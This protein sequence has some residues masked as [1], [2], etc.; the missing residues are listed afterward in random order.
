MLTKEQKEEI[1]ALMDEEKERLGTYSA[2][3]RKCGVS[4]ST[5]SQLRKGVYLGDNDEI[6][7]K[8]GIA[9]NY[10]FEEGCWQ[11]AEDITNFRIVADTLTDAKQESM[12]MGISHR[13][14]SGKTAAAEVFT[15]R[16]KRR[17]VFMITAREWSGK[18]F[19]TRLAGELG[20]ELPKGI[21]TV[22]Q[23][24]DAIA[25]AVTKM[26]ALKPLLI[27]DQANS[28]KPSALRS[29]IHL[30]NAVEDL[31]G[32]VII[33]TENLETEIKR[34]IRL[35][36]LGYDEFDSR[37]GRNYIHLLGATLADVRKIC[38]LNGIDDPSTQEALF[39]KCQPKQTTVDDEKTRNGKTIYVV[40]D[41]R[42]L[43]RLIMA[44]LLNRKYNE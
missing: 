31:L 5:V 44:E 9:L 21:L 29:F 24:I 32:V 16:N 2:V 8:I 43:K 28:L 7:K 6:L 34:G 19:L 38:S 40:E 39:R 18:V 12:F 20:A 3:A 15:N 27:V 26:A 30:F 22:D 33:G 14:G 1:I 36:K 42:R 13:A 4:E 10:S 41:I 25:V 23:L 35:N 37:F 11:I 17:A